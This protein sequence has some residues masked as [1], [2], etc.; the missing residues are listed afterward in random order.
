MEYRPNERTAVTFDVNNLFDTPAQR[1]RL[2]F[3]P[4]RATPD[5]ALREFR[6]RDSHLTLGITLKRSFGGAK[7][8]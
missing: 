2:M 6:V 1:E 5:L 3:L 8:G 4:N 7:A